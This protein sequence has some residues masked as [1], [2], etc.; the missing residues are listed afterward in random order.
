MK[1]GLLIR[2]TSHLIYDKE[3]TLIVP[4]MKVCAIKTRDVVEK[5]RNIYTNFAPYKFHISR[6]F[7]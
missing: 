2:K 3:G 7:V 5:N 4:R 6:E 1:S